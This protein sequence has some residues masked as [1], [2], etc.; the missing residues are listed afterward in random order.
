[1]IVYVYINNIDT[2]TVNVNFDFKFE[3]LITDLRRRMIGTK[4]LFVLS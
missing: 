2:M 3:H 4:D 1:M